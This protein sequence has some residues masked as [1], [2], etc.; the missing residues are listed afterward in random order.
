MVFAFQLYLHWLV[1]GMAWYLILILSTQVNREIEK[2]PNLPHSNPPCF[3]YVLAIT[4]G[5]LT[6]LLGFR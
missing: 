3:F 5:L 2:F 6:W 4:C 1:Y